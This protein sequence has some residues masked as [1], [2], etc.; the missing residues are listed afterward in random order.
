M[1]ILTETLVVNP[2]ESALVVIDM[3]KDFCYEDSALF[4]GDTVEKTNWMLKYATITS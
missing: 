3:Q 4:M 2:V 1:V